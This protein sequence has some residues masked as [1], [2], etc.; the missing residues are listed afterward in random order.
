VADSGDQLLREIQEDLQREQWLRIWRAYGRYIAAV[1]AI[2]VVLVL[3]WL[4]WREWR[5]SR[6]VA[7]GHAYWLADRMDMLGDNAGAAEA[8]GTLAEEGTEGY[9]MLARLRE[10]QALAATGDTAGAVAAYDAVAADTSIA[11]EYRL[12]GNLYA[13]ILLLDVDSAEAVASRLQPV[14]ADGSPWRHSALEVQGL[15]ALKTGDR[16]GAAAIFDGLV[17]DPATP[18]TLRARAAELA[19]IARGES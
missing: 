17:A 9:V 12:L 10:A 3:A 16:D 6:L 7:D 15:L 8:F 14:T 13:A 5:E 4:G 19:A 1:V 2:V 18:N 11:R